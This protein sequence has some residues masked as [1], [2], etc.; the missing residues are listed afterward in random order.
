MKQVMIEKVTLN[1]GVG[2]AGEKVNKAV[3]VLESIS[4]QKAVKTVTQKRIPTWNVRPG[5]SIA[6]KVTIRGAKAELLLKR[7]LEAVENN[8]KKR[9]F[10]ALGNFSFGIRSYID[11][12]DMSYDPGVGIFGLDVAVTFKRKGYRVKLRRFIPSRIGSSHVVTP[13]DSIEFLKEK[14]GVKVR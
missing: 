11:I 6:A 14:Y 10:D 4:G 5:V 12:P 8:V 1:I 2:E 7:L 3:K 13:E 9:S